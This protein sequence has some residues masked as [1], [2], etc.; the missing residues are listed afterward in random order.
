MN[1]YKIRIFTSFFVLRFVSIFNANAVSPLKTAVVRF[2]VKNTSSSLKL[3][4]SE[5]HLRYQNDT[6]KLRNG[7]CEKIIKLSK[8]IYVSV[9]N[10]EFYGQIFVAPG[11][12]S[13][14][15]IDVMK[16][17]SN[18]NVRF[19]SLGDGKIANDYL[20]QTRVG[21]TFPRTKIADKPVSE[22][23]YL[24]A[25]DKYFFIRDSIC[26]SHKKKC[27]THN[28][29]EPYLALFFDTEQTNTR[30]CRGG[31]LLNLMSNRR[32][33]KERA[34]TFFA[35]HIEPLGL[36]KEQV[37]IESFD[38]RYFFFSYYL[39]YVR[40]QSWA[41]DSTLMIKNGFGYNLILSTKIYQGQTHRFVIA[42]WLNFLADICKVYSSKYPPIDLL[43]EQYGVY[44]DKADKAFL[45]AKYKKN[46]Q[47]DPT[48]YTENEII[49]DF[50]VTDISRAQT[51]FK[52]KLAQVTLIDLWTTWCG[53]CVEGFA[54]IEQIATHYADNKSI[55]FIKVSLDTKI[56]KWQGTCQRLKIVDSPNNFWVGGELNSPF[57]KQFKVLYL[58]RIILLNQEGKI[59]KLFA[60]DPRGKG[61]K[62]LIAIIDKYLER[63]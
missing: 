32:Y 5:D 12:K 38:S 52:S 28:Q 54:D 31:L 22:N 37:N 21:M 40:D 19:E 2:E 45:L 11:Y 8:P 3:S 16:K 49:K 39:G 58:P 41:T 26:Y 42:S 30:F 27:E 25:V 4:Y 61:R 48:E 47:S 15:V 56:E 62:E 9:R 1:V 44:I 6:L 18:G 24:I 14:F 63:N 36:H 10:D 43:I 23:E 51:N 13:K 34:N 7:V 59:L 55:S 35:K 46:S 50:T 17:T 29:I 33:S 57:S 60:P 20:N 53:N